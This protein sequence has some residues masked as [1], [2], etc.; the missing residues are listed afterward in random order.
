M[1]KYDKSQLYTE[2]SRDEGKSILPYQDTEGIWS[3]GI[4]RNLEANSLPIN[5]LVAVIRRAGGLLETEMG[6]MLTSDVTEAESALSSLLSDW[7]TYLTPVRQRVLLNM[8]FNL[9]Q[10]RLG[11]FVACRWQRFDLLL[12]RID[13]VEVRFESLAVLWAEARM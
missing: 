11:R 9:G 6:E 3:A 2:L 1:L 12:Q 5:I 4:G 10:A 8:A 7:Q 13:A